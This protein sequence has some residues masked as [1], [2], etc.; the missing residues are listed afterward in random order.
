MPVY[1]VEA[2]GKEYTFVHAHIPKTGGVAVS[3]YFSSYLRAKVYFGYE[4][5]RIRPMLRCHPHHYHYEMLNDL[6]ALEKAACCFSIVRHPVG[7]MQS[8]Y[9]WA[10]TRS[11]IRQNYMP[12]DEWVP[13]V[14]DQ[15]NKDPF[16]LGNHIRPQH[17][18]VGKLISN[19]YRFEDGLEVAVEKALKVAGL[20]VDGGP[21]LDKINTR[22][23][24]GL[25]P[26]LSVEMTHDTHR[27]IM[28]FYE[29]DLRRF[30]YS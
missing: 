4:M 17:E 15:Y 2:G 12:F 3:H 26:M 27:M 18:F 29:A 1:V 9:V 25:D 6:L 7:R 28:Q 22:D 13:R 5:N 19:V 21:V 20:E 30:N 14:F 10:M 11:P 23:E 8:D 16:L 24:A